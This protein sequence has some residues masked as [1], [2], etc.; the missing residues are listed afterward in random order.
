MVKR[1]DLN[2]D[3]EVGHG[4]LIILRRPVILVHLL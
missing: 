3:G 2:I 4:G 1:E